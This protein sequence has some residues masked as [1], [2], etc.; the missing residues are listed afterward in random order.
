MGSYVVCGAAGVAGNGEIADSGKDRNELLQRCDRPEALSCSLT[1]SKRQ[2]RIFGSVIQPLMG[3]VLNLWHDLASGGAVGVQ[4]VC[5]H[6][7]RRHSLL[8]QQP[9]QQTLGGLGVPA[10][11]DDLVEHIAVLVDRS[12]QPAFAPIDADN[13][14]VEVPDVAERGR[15][16]AQAAR[17]IGTVGPTPPAD[18]LIRNSD[19]ALEH[20]FLDLAQPHIEAEVEPDGSGNNLDWKAMILVGRHRAVHTPRLPQV[21]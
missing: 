8:L 4:L 5:D 16:A 19:T 1:L 10:G 14:L 2:V 20:H 6:P 12:P 7:L 9:G 15:L 3:A 18:R 17:I 13:K 21:H 11:L